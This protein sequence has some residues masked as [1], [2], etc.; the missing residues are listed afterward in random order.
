MHFYIKKTKIIDLIKIAIND[1]NYQIE[2]FN[3]NKIYEYVFFDIF[4]GIQLKWSK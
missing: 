2:Y 4:T 3:P 1:E